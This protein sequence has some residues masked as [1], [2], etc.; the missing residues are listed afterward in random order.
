MGAFFKKGYAYWDFESAEISANIRNRWER[1]SM[2][3]REKVKR[4]GT[5]DSVSDSDATFTLTV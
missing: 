5:C 1:C 2:Q 3:T 4:R